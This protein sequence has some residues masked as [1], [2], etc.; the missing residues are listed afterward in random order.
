[1]S[2][3]ILF[4]RTLWQPGWWAGRTTV[5]IWTT[6]RLAYLLMP[7]KAIVSEKL[8]LIDMQ[9]LKTVCQCIN[10]SPLS[11]DTLTRRLVNG[12]KH[13]SN[14]EDATIN[15][16]WSLWMILRWRK[17]LW[18]ICKVLKPF[19]KA[20]TGHDKYSLRNRDKLQQPY[21]MRL[22]QEQEIFYE[23]FFAFYKARLNFE[24]FRK[25]E[26]PHSWFISEINDTEKGFK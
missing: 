26:E 1:M 19:L 22:S 16:Y 20:L 15:S 24:R 21:Q 2:K 9:S 14:M 4:E 8:S 25:K 7:M 3:K 13:S 23:L 11:Y 12:N 18:L 5:E 6:A 10:K 17:G